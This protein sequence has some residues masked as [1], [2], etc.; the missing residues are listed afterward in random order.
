MKYAVTKNPRVGVAYITIMGDVFSLTAE[1]LYPLI[2]ESLAYP[3]KSGKWELHLRA[4]TPVSRDDF[5]FYVDGRD[6]IAELGPVDYVDD[7]R[8]H[9]VAVYLV[10]ENFQEQA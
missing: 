5:P 1:I 10:R 4:E 8:L 7:T 9:A 6:W 3:S 2:E